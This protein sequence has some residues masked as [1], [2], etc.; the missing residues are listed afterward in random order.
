MAEQVDPLLPRQHTYIPERGTYVPSWC[1]WD[2]Q[3]WPTYVEVSQEKVTLGYKVSDVLPERRWAIQQNGD[4]LDQRAFED[5]Y[6]KYLSGFALPATV[7]INAEAIPRVE[8]Y[9]G[10]KIDPIA[11]ERL[12]EMHY[13]PFKRSPVVPEAKYNQEGE[14]SVHY[15]QEQQEKTDKLVRM[16]QLSGLLKD[17]IISQETY[18]RLVDELGPVKEPE[19]VETAPEPQPEPEPKQMV[20]SLC[21]VERPAGNSI[22]M[23]ERK[24]K[25]CIKIREEQGHI[26]KVVES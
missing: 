10:V 21:G 3:K 7:D 1:P 26:R 16:E 18:L 17:S 19:K 2:T 20:T 23:H 5:Q 8:R 12:V 9:V 25:K 6:K 14:I 24:C 11:P 22:R 4:M 13:D 15:L